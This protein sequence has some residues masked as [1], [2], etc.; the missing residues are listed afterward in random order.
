MKNTRESINQQVQFIIKEVERNIV[1]VVVDGENSR[2]FIYDTFEPSVNSSTGATSF[3]SG[4]MLEITDFLEVPRH[5]I[6]TVAF[7]QALQRFIEANEFLNI[8]FCDK[9]KWFAYA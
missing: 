6:R 9:F 7:K 2:F 3:S 8:K 5:D 4:K 1:E